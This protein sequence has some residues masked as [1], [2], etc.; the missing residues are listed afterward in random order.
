MG[1]EVMKTKIKVGDGSQLPYEV[2]FNRFV[3]DFLRF[4]TTKL[5]VDVER[6]VL[7]YSSYATTI[8]GGD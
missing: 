2:S 1:G 7:V 8:P 6:P 3:R 5:A 4:A